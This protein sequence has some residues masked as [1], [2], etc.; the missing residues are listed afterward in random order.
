[1]TGK[2]REELTGTRGMKYEDESGGEASGRSRERVGRRLLGRRGLSEPSAPNCTSDAPK[3][4]SCPLASCA[5]PLSRSPEA[6]RAHPSRRLCINTVRA[7]NMRRKGAGLSAALWRSAPLHRPILHRCLY[8][9]TARGV[10]LAAQ[11]RFSPASRTTQSY[12]HQLDRP[13]SRRLSSYASSTAPPRPL[14]A[15]EEEVMAALQR[16]KHPGQSRANHARAS[17]D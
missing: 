7:V 8:H 14:S 11:P 5:Y 9:S 10:R 3:P 17:D 6:A 16:V 13:L 4:H 12:H 1:M 2:L 15:R